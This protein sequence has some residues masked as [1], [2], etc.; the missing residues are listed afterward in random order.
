M[1]LYK[2]KIALAL[3]DV[4]TQASKITIVDDAEEYIKNRQFIPDPNVSFDMY[5]G[6]RPTK[7]P[8]MSRM[9][10]EEPPTKRQKALFNQPKKLSKKQKAKNRKK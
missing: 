8:R 4:I 3:N 10:D 2:T 5:T 6:E 9:I 7:A 1:S